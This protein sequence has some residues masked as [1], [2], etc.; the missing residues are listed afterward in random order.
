MNS[1][2]KKYKQSKITLLYLIKENYGRYC[3]IEHLEKLDLN[4]ES[5]DIQDNVIKIYIQDY[6]ATTL[7]SWNILNI[8]KTVLTD[9]DL[10]K[11]EK[12][13]KEEKYDSQKDYYKEYL[14]ICLLIGKYIL[15]YYM[16]DLSK[17]RVDETDIRY[18]KEDIQNNKVSLCTHFDL[19]AGIKAWKLLELNRDDIPK[20]AIEAKRENIKK[21]LMELDN[22]D[23]SGD[24]L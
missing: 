12:R 20:S 13:L 18:R 17:S 24:N 4:Y 10:R 6:E 5:T 15:E 22:I 19:K 11:I 21:K 2:F 23:I 7:L 9:L 16:Y 3:S 8:N 14:K 1:S